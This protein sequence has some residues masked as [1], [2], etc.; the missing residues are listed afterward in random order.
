[1]NLCS[2]EVD[3]ELSRVMLAIH[4][5]YYVVRLVFCIFLIV[6]YFVPIVQLYTTLFSIILCYGIEY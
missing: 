1:M 6:L 5:Y 3:P 4:S 2:E